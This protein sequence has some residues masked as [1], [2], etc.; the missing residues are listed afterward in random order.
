M[1]GWNLYFGI[2]RYSYCML[3]HIMQLIYLVSCEEK[4]SNALLKVP[5]AVSALLYVQLF[6][7]QS[8]HLYLVLIFLLR[9]HSGLFLFRKLYSEFTDNLYACRYSVQFFIFRRYSFQF[10][11]FLLYIYNC[12]YQ[13][14]LFIYK[15]Q[16]ETTWFHTQKI[17]K[18]A[19]FI[20]KNAVVEKCFLILDV[21]LVRVH[22]LS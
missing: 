1:T 17:F 15:L 13:V 16:I 3:F 5:C 14:G 7:V 8:P 9:R 2:Q 18:Q 11:I 21:E 12:N 10:F 19:V 6:S 4:H 22:F 20:Y